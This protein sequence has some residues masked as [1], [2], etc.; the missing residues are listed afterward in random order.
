MKSFKCGIAF[1]KRM[2]KLL[3]FIYQLKTDFDQW[4][5]IG[6]VKSKFKFELLILY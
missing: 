6:G 5:L 1:W 2:E 3:D 4:L